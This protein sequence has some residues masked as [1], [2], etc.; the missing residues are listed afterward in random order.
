[1]GK[2]VPVRLANG[3]SWSQKGLAAKHFRA[4]LGRHIVGAQ[5]LDPGDISDLTSLIEVYAP[6][7]TQLLSVEHGARKTV[8]IQ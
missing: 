2:S 8:Y 6:R 7:Y 5:V 3:R 1:M 4:I